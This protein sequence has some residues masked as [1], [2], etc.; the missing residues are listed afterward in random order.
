MIV[1]VGSLQTRK[2]AG[3][4]RQQAVRAWRSW[5]KRC[6]SE[7]PRR[8]TPLPRFSGRIISPTPLPQPDDSYEFSGADEEDEE[9]PF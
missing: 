1:V 3:Q 2:L 5:L 9:L 4:G 6:F 7:N 8:A